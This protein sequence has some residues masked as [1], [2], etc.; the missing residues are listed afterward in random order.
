MYLEAKLPSRPEPHTRLEYR[1]FPVYPQH[2]LAV[3][4]REIAAD[5]YRVLGSHGLMELE[6]AVADLLAELLIFRVIFETTDELL[7]GLGTRPL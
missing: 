1:A 3:A 7:M 6:C 5:Q 4:I 2:H